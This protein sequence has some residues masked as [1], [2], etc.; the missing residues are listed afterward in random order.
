MALAEAITWAARPDPVAEP[1]LLPEV[2]YI[3]SELLRDQLHLRSG[4]IA[5]AIADCWRAGCLPITVADPGWVPAPGGLLVISLMPQAEQA[6]EVVDPGNRDQL[7]RLTRRLIS[8]RLPTSTLVGAPRGLDETRAAVAYLALAAA[9]LPVGG[10]LPHLE[11]AARL[12]QVTPVHGAKAEAEGSYR[13]L[14]VRASAD[15]A[16]DLKIPF[17][18]R[19]FPWPTRVVD[20]APEEA[21]SVLEPGAPPE[22]IG[23]RVLASVRGEARL[24]HLNA[25][26]QLAG[27]QPIYLTRVPRRLGL[28]FYRLDPTLDAAARRPIVDLLG[29]LE[30]RTDEALFDAVIGDEPLTEP[31]PRP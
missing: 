10:P 30:G 27:L 6:D 12:G 21:I 26:A 3:P 16:P 8:L 14:D 31:R 22:E 23:R 20:L 2:L 7:K 9:A 19:A 13:L 5:R 28:A 11:R 4:A 18:D 1:G 15:P 24:R 25:V 17:I 29:T